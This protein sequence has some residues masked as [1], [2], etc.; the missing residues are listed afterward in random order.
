MFN[1]YELVYKALPFYAFTGCDTLSSFFNHD[2]VDTLTCVFS[3]LVD[4]P[5]EVSEKEFICIRKIHDI[6][7]L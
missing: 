7:L 1:A 2:N 4:K 5:S 3:K 6:C